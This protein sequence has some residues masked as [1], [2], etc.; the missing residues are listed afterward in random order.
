M[1][2]SRFAFSFEYNDGVV[3]F[4]TLN[5]AVV[6][7]DKE[8]FDMLIKYCSNELRLDSAK[9]GRFNDILKA[10]ES[11]HILV[12]EEENENRTY[13]ALTGEIKYSKSSLKYTILTTYDCNMSCTYCVQQEERKNVYMSEDTAHKVADWI[14]YNA[15]SSNCRLLVINYYGGEPLLNFNAIRILNDKLKDFCDEWN[16]KFMVR[17]ITNGTLLSD[18]I[19]DYLL[20]TN[21]HGIQITLDG[22]KDLHDKRRIFKD[23]SGSF[24]IVYGN[25]KKVVYRAPDVNV[26]VRMNLDKENY[27]EIP[28]LLDLL[29]NDHLHDKVFISFGR[30]IPPLKC[31]EI[32]PNMF[33]EKEFSKIFLWLIKECIKR[34]F[35]FSWSLKPT[36]VSCAAVCSN[37]LIIDP[38]GRFYKCLDMIQDEFCVGSINDGFNYRY[39]EWV[40][41]DPLE[42]DVCRNCTLLPLC[43]GGCPRLAYYTK[44]TIHSPYCSSIKYY[45]KKF[46]KMYIDEKYKGRIGESSSTG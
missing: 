46:L 39:Y 1:K 23:G 7:L 21:L 6:Y 44:G 22:P 26:A 29:V 33:A 2:I 4:N 32:P 24:D 42:Y 31:R 13:R 19:L 8:A 25:I 3:I 17:M 20:D 34:G 28:R 35:P 45:F 37:S 10:L 5:S 12:P 14:I 16:I 41:R 18:R 27:R 40:S 30:I 11:F 36:F 43:G 9:L 15:K 38:N